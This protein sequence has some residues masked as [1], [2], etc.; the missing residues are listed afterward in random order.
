MRRG[1]ARPQ[2]AP[3]QQR[4]PVNSGGGL[5]AGSR[6]MLTNLDPQLT[7]EDCHE[8]FQN[9]GPVTKT[10]IHYN[11]DGSSLGTAEV[12]FVNKNDA[13]RAVDEYDAAQ[14][15][16]R[17]MYVKVI[18]NKTPTVVQ[19]APPMMAPPAFAMLTMPTVSNFRG[20]GGGFINNRGRGGPPRGGFRRGS[21]T[22][23]RG[24]G[25]NFR[26]RGRGRGGNRSKQPT[27]TASDLDADMDKYYSNGTVDLIAAG[28]PAN[29]SVAKK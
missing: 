17:P 5:Q 26:A 2:T 1:R 21:G 10:V 7:E 28:Q 29:P 27:P 13:M 11:R 6:I 14:I 4:P 16:G 18:A 20:G 25:G 12:H 24:G 3:Y 23:Q 8:I 9:V 22:Q 19:R 15:D